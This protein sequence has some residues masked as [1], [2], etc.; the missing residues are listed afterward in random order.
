[1]IAFDPTVSWGAIIN[2]LVLLAGFIAAFTRIGGLI[3][4]MNLRLE[5]LEKAVEKLGDNNTR[6]AI[7]EERVTNHGKMIAT[8]QNIIEDLRH[9]NGFGAGARSGVDGAY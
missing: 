6:I 9:G 1:M 5:R 3:G 7:L 4:L 2:A 8:N